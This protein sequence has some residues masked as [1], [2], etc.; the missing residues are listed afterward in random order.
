MKGGVETGDL[1]ERGAQLA[2][3]LDGRQIVRLV[4]RRERRE[5][6]EPGQCVRIDD[7]RCVVMLAAMHDPVAGADQM[8]RMTARLQPVKQPGERG[9]VIHGGGG[10]GT[11]QRLSVVMRRE[12]RGRANAGNHAL[13]RALQ[14]IAGG[15]NRKLDAR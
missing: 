12:C 11:G 13:R 2:Q 10:Q 9:F 6:F 3:R 8:T 7:D 15:K 14:G 4:Q 5:R 1:S